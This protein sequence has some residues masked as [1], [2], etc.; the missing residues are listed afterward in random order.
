[1]RSHGRGRGQRGA[2]LVEGALVMSAFVILTVSIVDVAHFFHQQHALVEQTRAAVRTGSVRN[3][4]REEIA[5]MVVFGQTRPPPGTERGFQGLR[6]DNVGVEILDHGTAE[7]RIVV[8][9]RGLKYRLIT[10][11]LPGTTD[12]L[13]LQIASPLESQ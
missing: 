10:P 4:S 11:L 8:T 3:L 12:N 6:L 9:I 7:Q 5:S 1:M 13:R 2:A